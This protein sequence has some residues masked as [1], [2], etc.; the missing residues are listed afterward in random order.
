MSHFKDIL[1]LGDTSIA[2]TKTIIV[3]KATRTYPNNRL[4]EFLSF[5]KVTI[6]ECV[7]YGQKKTCDSCNI[8]QEA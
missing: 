8:I 5:V 7:N 1:N 3:M 6:L 2:D 4:Y